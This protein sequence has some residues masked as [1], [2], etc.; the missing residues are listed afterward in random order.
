MQLETDLLN[1][2]SVH[3]LKKEAVAELARKCGESWAEIERIK[4]EGKIVEVEY[5]GN[6]FYLRNV[7]Q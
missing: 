4:E 6:R 1:I 2:S 7:E 5:S 3:P